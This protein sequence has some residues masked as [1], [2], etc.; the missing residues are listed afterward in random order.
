MDIAEAKEFLK[1]KEHG[2]LVARKK[3]GR[4]RP[5]AIGAVHAH[6]VGPLHEEERISFI[7]IGR[8]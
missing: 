8:L 1:G 3:D 4:L 7:R 5:V 2:V 6:G